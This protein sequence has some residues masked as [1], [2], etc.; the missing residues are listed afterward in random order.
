[1]SGH[2]ADIIRVW[3]SIE[4]D[5]ILIVDRHLVGA[6]TVSNGS[7]AVDRDMNGARGMRQSRP[8]VKDVPNSVT[9]E[10]NGD[11]ICSD[12]HCHELQAARLP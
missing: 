11:A 7:I 5:T 1:M 3:V 12:N 6:R 9:G 2:P 4:P 8:N 10:M